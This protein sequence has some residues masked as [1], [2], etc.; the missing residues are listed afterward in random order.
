MVGSKQ[1][2]GIIKHNLFEKSMV[3]FGE[4]SS[5]KVKMREAFMINLL[6]QIHLEWK[7][8]YQ[9]IRTENLGTKTVF[10]EARQPQRLVLD[11]THSSLLAPFHLRGI[12]LS[13]Y[14][15]NSTKPFVMANTF[16]QFPLMLP[17][18]YMLVREN[19]RTWCLLCKT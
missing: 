4:L 2:S 1:E 18:G 15:S 5:L 7:I 14:F 19:W 10:I 17:L 16:P 6:E 3:K 13:I 12:I 11:L 8:F 9:F